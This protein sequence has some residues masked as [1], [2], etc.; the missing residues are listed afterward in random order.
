M[1][2]LNNVI[3]QIIVIAFVSALVCTSGCSTSKV[4]N[5]TATVKQLR[6]DPEVKTGKLENGISYFILE[7]AEPKNRINL[8]LVVKAGS[9]LEDDDQKGIAFE[10]AS[11]LIKRVYEVINKYSKQFVKIRQ[12]NITKVCSYGFSFSEVD[13]PYINKIINS[14]KV[15]KWYLDRFSY[16]NEKE[17]RRIKQV[18]K[19]LG[20]KGKVRRF[21]C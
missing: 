4:Q 16:D 20:F 15:K 10:A 14:V 7:N 11:K 17:L 12:S 1:K 18:L 21:Q 3:K 6:M 13:L 19:R 9:I 2:S 8:R 5:N